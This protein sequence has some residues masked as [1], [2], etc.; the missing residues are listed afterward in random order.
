MQDTIEPKIICTGNPKDRGIAQSLQQLYP[1]TEFLSRTSGYDFH[2]FS[3]ITESR[4]RSR[5]TNFNVLI[6]YSW[7][8]Y[9]V[10]ERILNIAREEWTHGHVINI[11]SSNEDCEIRTRAEPKYTAD[12]INLRKASL[13]LNNENFKTT[14]IVVGGFQATSPGSDHGMDPMH[15]AK[16]IKWILEA[17]YEIPIIGIQQSTDYI[18][19]FLNKVSKLEPYA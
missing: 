3:M 4:L 12:K 18:R 14:H 7:V 16:L 11:G 2:E 15:Y 9:G 1:D 17:P 8:T 10:Q 19:S 13:K 5:L 6:N